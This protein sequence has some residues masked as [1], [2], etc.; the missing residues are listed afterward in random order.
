MGSARPGRKF[1]YVTDSIRTATLADEVAGSDLLICEG[2]FDSELQDAAH[3]KGHMTAEDAGKLARDAGGVKQMGLIHYSP[4]YTNRQLK[5]LQKEAQAH[6]PDT[7]LTRDQQTISIP[8]P[9]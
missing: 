1:S 6:F 4:R 7:F 3:E 9:E 5:K 8:Y 2:M